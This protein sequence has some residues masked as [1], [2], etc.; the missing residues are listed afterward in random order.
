MQNQR[1]WVSRSAVRKRYGTSDSS[2]SRW[3]KAGMF[4]KPKR[5]GANTDRW[6]GVELDEHDADPEGW[7]ARNN[8][9][10]AAA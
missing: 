3:V 5:I 10:D 8:K 7:K 4:P 2:I 6:D 1:R 9:Q